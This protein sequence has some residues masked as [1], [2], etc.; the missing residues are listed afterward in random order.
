MLDHEELKWFA[1]NATE[2]NRV[3]RQAIRQQGMAM[4]SQISG[5]QERTPQTDYAALPGFTTWPALAQLQ[6][7]LPVKSDTP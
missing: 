4:I 1:A 2:L 6:Q 7:S 3:F 5:T